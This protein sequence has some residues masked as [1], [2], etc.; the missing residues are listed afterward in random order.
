MLDALGREIDYMRVSVTD[1][2]NL[3]CKYCMPCD[4]PS[5]PHDSVLRYEEFLRLCGIAAGIGVRNIKVTGGEPLARK[6][7]VAFIRELKR[8]PGI[9][10]VTLTTNGVLLGPRVAELAEMGL[11]GV[12]IS[13]D[14][15]DAETSLRIT[16]SESLPAALR[17]LHGAVDAGLRVKVNFVPLKGWNDSEIVH[18]ARLAEKLPVDVRFIELMP[19]AC[20][21]Q[22]ERVPGSEVLELLLREYP[23]LEPDCSRHGFGPA[24]YYRS[25][26]LKGGVGL[27]D[28][29]SNHFCGAC[30]RVRLTSE[31]FLKLCLFHGEGLDLR[32]M[33]RAGA[34]DAEI[35]EAMAGAV[36][37]K[38]ERHFFGGCASANSGIGMMSKIGG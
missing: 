1:R 12:N 35:R 4:L 7:C 29:V 20:G 38:P 31:G 2:C 27:I 32:G 3:R 13:L 37:E 17:A 15:L 28:S 14:S 36:R 9:E 6:G 23:D 25:E 16:G 34:S 30:N 21:E 22:F 5:I 8:L 33:L 24:R 19:T 26:R 11:D 18:M 10:H